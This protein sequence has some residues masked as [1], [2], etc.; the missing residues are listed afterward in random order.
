MQN[1]IQIIIEPENLLNL[2]NQIHIRSIKQNIL[3]TKW[4]LLLGALID[5]NSEFKIENKNIGM[6]PLK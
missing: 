3:Y 2:K 5:G 6:Y 1:F 4:W